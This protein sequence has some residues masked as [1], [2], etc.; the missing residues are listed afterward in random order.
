MPVANV[1]S[2][3]RRKFQKVITA[4]AIYT[5]RCTT[6]LDFVLGGN[7]PCAP[8]LGRL[9]PRSKLR[10][11]PLL[12]SE[13]KGLTFSVWLRLSKFYDIPQ[14]P[15]V[16]VVVSIK[17]PDGWYVRL[18]FPSPVVISYVLALVG[19]DNKG[20]G[21]LSPH[22]LHFTGSVLQA[23]HSA[24]A[25][26]R[27]ITAVPP[28]GSTR[29]GTV[30]GCPS[31]DRGSREA[32]VGFE[33]T[34][35]LIS[36]RSVARTRHLPLDF[37]LSRLGQPGIILVLPLPSGGMAVRQQNNDTAEVL[38]FRT[39]GVCLSTTLFSCRYQKDLR[40][41]QTWKISETV[42]IQPI[43][44]FL[45]QHAIHKILKSINSYGYDF[46]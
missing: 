26:F 35:L 5:K 9:R 21:V 45:M 36:K 42:C 2:R 34:D 7:R 33:S 39:N 19:V 40:F 41:R 23:T 18:T 10:K 3:T 14:K 24:V 38:L 46:L 32:E 30:P 28:E 20:S 29:V 15:L 17:S 12:H 25:L 8:L 37:L 13:N 27:C 31:V 22:C 43:A 1:A 6:V 44:R 16:T 11:V 4:Y